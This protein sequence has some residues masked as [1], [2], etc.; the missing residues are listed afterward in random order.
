M[1]PYL[2]LLYALG[3]LAAQA[4][5]EPVLPHFD[6]ADFVPGAAID[7]P[8]LPLPP[9]FRFESVGMRK[10]DAG[11]LVEERTVITYVGPGPI[12][13]GVASTLILDEVRDAGVLVEQTMDYFAQD[14]QGNVW[15]L[16]EDSVEFTYDAKGQIAAKDPAGSWHAG[17][18]GALPGLAMPAAPKPGFAYQQEHAPAD[19][20]L[21][22]AEIVGV[23]GSLTIAGQVYDHVLSIVETTP[24]EP[25]VAEMKYYA[26]G[27]GVIR[28]EEGLDQNRANPTM[29]FDRVT[30]GG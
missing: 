23:A 20:A 24:L 17:V 22:Q 11:N 16:G 10:D 9:G 27:V 12:L 6:P 13:G 29:H 25:G 15:Y 4:H 30:S 14:R 1:K 18:N 3:V 2:P 21:D 8:Y 26:P 28:V 19:G 7:N 5:A